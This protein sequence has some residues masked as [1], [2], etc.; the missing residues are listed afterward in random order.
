MRDL[1]ALY[2][3]YDEREVYFRTGLCSRCTYRLT[4]DE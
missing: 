2:I 4:K 3:E 1:R